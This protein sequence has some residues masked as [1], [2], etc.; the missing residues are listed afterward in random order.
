MSLKK[1]C[2]SLKSLKPSRESYLVFKDCLF[3]AL[4]SLEKEFELNCDEQ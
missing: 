4:I 2:E 1:I 3:Y